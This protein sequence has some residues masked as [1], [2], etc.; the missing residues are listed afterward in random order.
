MTRDRMP[1]DA[2]RKLLR[3]A[4]GA[5]SREVGG[6]VLFGWDVVEMPNNSPEDGEYSIAD[7]VLLDFYQCFPTPMGFFHSHPKGRKD[8]SNTD[9]DYAPIG[10]RYWIVTHQGV[11]EWDMSNGSP[12]FVG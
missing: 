3:L 2:Q 8:P 6:F 1:I 5:G 11:Y 12:A 4:K 10:L 7:Q 9:V